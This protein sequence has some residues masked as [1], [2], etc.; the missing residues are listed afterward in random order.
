MRRDLLAR[1]QAGDEAAREQLVAENLSLVRHMAARFHNLGYD[2][3]DL[4]QVGCLGLLKAID[5][6]DLTMDVQFST[7]AVPLILGE[8]RRFLR[9]DGPLKV[10]RSLKSLALQAKRK[11]EELTRELGRE[12]AV[13]EVAA[14]LGCAVQD[15]V[16]ALESLQGPASLDAPVGAEGDDAYSLAERIAGDDGREA[17]FLDRMALGQVLEQIPDRDREILVRRFYQSQTQSEVAAALGISQVQVSRLERR[18]LLHLRGL[19]AG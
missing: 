3:Q 2:P 5:R 19:L 15:L 12:P 16:E 8:I 13:Q 7:Y 10:S 14:A 6:F 18:A 17:P 9:D 11:T 1:A 4:F